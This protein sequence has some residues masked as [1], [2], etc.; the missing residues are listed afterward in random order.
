M[1]LS[2][3]GKYPHFGWFWNPMKALYLVFIDFNSILVQSSAKLCNHRKFSQILHNGMTSVRFFRNS[4]VRQGHFI[5]PLRCLYYGRAYAE[6]DWLYTVVALSFTYLIGHYHPQMI[7]IP[8]FMSTP[9]ERLEKFFMTILFAPR[10]FGINCWEE[11]AKWKVK[12]GEKKFRI[13]WYFFCFLMS[14]SIWESI[15]LVLSF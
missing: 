8:L 4:I 1:K 7:K 10:D 2:G 5:S 11:V 9:N 3:S 6:I 14:V 13:L 12:F 15:V